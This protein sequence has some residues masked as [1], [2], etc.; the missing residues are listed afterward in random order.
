MF[1]CGIFIYALIWGRPFSIN[2]YFDRTLI[3]IL[4]DEPQ[5]LSSLGLIDNTILDF[6][7]DELSDASDERTLEF[8][9]Q[10]EKELETLRSYYYEGLNRSQ[11]LSYK[12]AEWM[13]TKSLEGKQFIYHSYPVNQIS[14]IQNELPSFMDATHQIIDEKSARRYAIRLS[15]FGRVFDQTVEMLKVRE[16]RNIVPPRFVLV[17]VIAQMS[18]F[19]AV[20]PEGNIL[21]TSFTKKLADVESL[22]PPIKHKL[23]TK[24]LDEIEKTVYPAYSKMIDYLRHLESVAT[25]DDGAWKL[26]NG[27]AFYRFMLSMATTTNMTPDE[28]H[29]LGLSEVYRIQKEM[30]SILDSL[31]HTGGTVG[32]WMQSLSEES[33][34]LFPDSDSGRA[35]IIS[36]YE[37][38]IR[39]ID[40]A[41]GTAFDLRPRAKVEVKRIP[42]FKEQTSAGAYYNQPAMDGSR[43][44]VFYANLRDVKEIPSF[45]MRTLAYHEAIPGHHYQLA[46]QLEMEGVPLFRRFPPFMA[47]VE[48]WA[49]YAERVAA[50]Y[51]FHTDPYSNLGRLQGELFRAV[52]LVVDTGIH[53]KR[54]TREEAINYMYDNT[55]IPR[56]DVISEIERY[57]VW[58]GQACAYKI[59]MEKILD[60]RS[61]ALTKLG[62][63]FDIREFHTTV[64]ENGAVPLEIL[65]QIVHDYVVEKMKGS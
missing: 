54:W 62:D 48:G 8:I 43:P 18:D 52:R 5:M 30:R 53:H 65:D 38:I 6:H 40:E 39:E 25:T 1:S 34:F 44:G 19:I 60:V 36:T 9:A 29:E 28:I 12:I 50:E 42:E 17:N 11:K 23:E 51:G 15:Q 21:F 31:G 24:V 41:L 3:K 16:D 64:L 7:S 22:N 4:M 49:L 63:Q 57:I 14:G 32:E 33:R 20:S 46:L 45:G 35:A 58:P 61:S 55:G 26:P 13:L 59:G 2:H 47:Y 37:E 10:A 27:D 56:S